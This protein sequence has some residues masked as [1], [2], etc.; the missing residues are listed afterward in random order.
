M[1]ARQ[2][3]LADR[4]FGHVRDVGV[5][6]EMH[7]HAERAAGF[8]LVAPAGLLG[9]QLE[10]AGHARRFVE[11][12]QAE[13][14][15]V[16]SGL[17]GQFVHQGFHD[18]AGMRVADRTPPQRTHRLLRRMHGHRERRNC[19]GRGF[20]PFAG[21]FVHAVFDVAGHDVR[22]AHD[23][24]ADDAVLPCGDGALT[25]ETD[26]RLVDV[27]RAVEAALHVI[28]ATPLHPNRRFAPALLFH[29]LG[30][31]D[32][33]H[34]EVGPGIGAPAEAAARDQGIE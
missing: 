14:H 13:F 3:V 34:R 2:A 28:L 12:R 1:H 10:H 18:E 31:V 25:V 9:R 26:L 24:L 7:G 4:D 21:R 8:G 6:R 17:F 20:D 15:R 11:Q 16:A 33:F 27:Q 32:G 5:E 30:D 19:V 23:R 22:G 29:R